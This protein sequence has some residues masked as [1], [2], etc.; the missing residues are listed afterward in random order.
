MAPS[1][2]RPLAQL[3][4]QRPDVIPRVRTNDEVA[5]AARDVSSRRSIHG[6]KLL[7]AVRGVL[8]SCEQMLARLLPSVDERSFLGLHVLRFSSHVQQ[9]S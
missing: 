9:S 2:S 7:S 3:V 8:Q 5:H 1:S 4:L 6:R